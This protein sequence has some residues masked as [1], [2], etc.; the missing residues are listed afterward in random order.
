MLNWVTATETN[1][2][3]FEIERRVEGSNTWINRGFEQGAGTSTQ[4]HSYSFSDDV[5]DLSAG[6]VFYRLKQIDFDGR[7]EYSDEVMVI[8]VPP[9]RF[10][11]AQNYPNPFNPTT[12][13]QYAIPVESHV[14]IK[15]L[16]AIGE[17]VAELLNETK[18]PGTY[19]INFNAKSLS[20]GVYFYRIQ[21]GNFV[22]TKRMML[23]K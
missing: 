20:S 10:N 3:G 18:A 4:T 16:N 7:F 5:S 23:I 9:T 22:E 12:V 17:E 8:S 11:L 14:T 19:E 21:A 2:L 15:V 6:S 1:N 13:I